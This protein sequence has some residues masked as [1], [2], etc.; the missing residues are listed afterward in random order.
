MSEGTVSLLATGLESLEP[1]I[2]SI[3]V[4]IQE[5][6]QEA[7]NELHVT[8]YLLTTGASHIIE[9]LEEAAKRG[10]RITFLVNRLEKQHP[11][12]RKKLKILDRHPNVDVVSFI[13]PRGGHL[14]AKVVVM[15]RTK[16]VIGSANL[17]WGGMVTNY[18]IGVLLQGEV[19]WKI[20]ELI[21]KLVLIAREWKKQSPTIE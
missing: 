15:D 9:R 5:L 12:V 1:S 10:V 4:V 2:R 20:A 6:I 17:S 16:A 7:R 18:E 8:A 3:D 14:H 11:L 21:D 13:D 19:A